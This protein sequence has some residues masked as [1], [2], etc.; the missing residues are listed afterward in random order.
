L[1]VTDDDVWHARASEGSALTGP[2]VIKPLTPAG[3]AG[4]VA[5]LMACAVSG[6]YA[7]GLSS[8]AIA[9]SEKSDGHV[10]E[11]WEIVL[12]PAVIAFAIV[13]G[14]IC[15]VTAIFGTRLTRRVRRSPWAFLAFLWL[16]PLAA[17]AAALVR[18]V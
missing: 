7:V 15:L 2:E 9:M 8:A 11:L 1:V 16:L 12:G 14:A 4:F 13:A 5:L 10:G 17:I 18:H 6:F 3:A